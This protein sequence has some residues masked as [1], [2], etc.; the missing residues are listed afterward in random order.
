M[1]EFK[2]FDALSV[3]KIQAIFMV[4]IALLAGIVTAIIG[5]IAMP[6]NLTFGRVIFAMGLMIAIFGAIGYGLAGFLSGIIFVAI[7]NLIAKKFGGI[8]YEN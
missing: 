4:F 1:K 6:F 7:Y 5:L 3:G 2:K 8:K